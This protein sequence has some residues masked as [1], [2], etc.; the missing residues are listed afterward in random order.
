MAQEIVGIPKNLLVYKPEQ[1]TT[2]LCWQIN[3]ET[4]PTLDL[5][6]FEVEVDVVADFSSINKKTFT[7]ENVSNYQSGTFFKAFII[8]DPLLFET[9]TY[10]WRV[11]V[12]SDDYISEWSNY[13]QESTDDFLDKLDFNVPT[14]IKNPNE[15][16][17]I[18][19]VKT[20]KDG[21]EM[22]DTNPP[23][24][25][26]TDGIYDRYTKANFIT[27]LGTEYGIT[28]NVYEYV[29]PY[30]FNINKITWYDDTETAERLLPDNYVYTKSGNTNIKRIIEMYMRLIGVFKDEA[31]QV[32]NN[33]NYKKIQDADLYDLLGV[34][35]TYTRNTEEPFITYKYELLNLWQAYLHQ[36]TKAAFDIILETFFG[37]KPT[38]QL[39]KGKVDETWYVYNQMPLLRVDGAT[40]STLNIT[41]GDAFYNANIDK[42]LIATHGST[43]GDWSD[44]YEQEPNEMTTYQLVGGSNL[45]N[46]QYVGAS[47]GMFEGT[48]DVERYYVRHIE[49]ID[50]IFYP[51]AQPNPFLYTNQYLAHN[52]LITVNNVYGIEVDKE[53]LTEI[54]NMLKPLNINILLDIKDE[55]KECEINF[56]VLDASNN[57]DLTSTTPVIYQVYGAVISTSDNS[58]VVVEG[59]DITYKVFKNGYETYEGTI[60]NVSGDQNITIKLEPIYNGLKFTSNGGSTIKYTY[61]GST[62]P[63]IKYRTKGNAW[64]TWNSNVEVS[65]AD[66]EYM[67]IK[68][69]NPTGVS[70]SWENDNTTF[71]MTGAGTVSASG[72]VNSILDDGDGSTIT[73]LSSTSYAYAYLFSGCSKLVKA[74][75]LPTMTLGENCYWGMFND[76]TGLEETPSL[77]ATTLADNCYY[78]MFNG[79]SNLTK[80]TPLPA[81]TMAERCYGGM[82][83]DCVSLTDAPQLPAT[84]LDEYCYAEMFDG[85]ISL[86]TM[87]VLSCT[88][89]ANACYFRMFQDCTSLVNVTN[90]TATELKIGCYD[91]MFKGCT[92][93]ETAPNI[94]MTTPTGS[95]LQEMFYGCSSLNSITLV[96]YMGTFNSTNFSNWVY[97]VAASGDFYYNGEDDT[98]S[99]NAI[100]IGW[101]V[102]N[103]EF[104][105]LRFRAEEAG[106]TISYSLNTITPDI[107]YSY[108]GEEWTTWN[109]NTTITLT[110]VGDVVYVKGNNPN[111]IGRGDMDTN[112]GYMQFITGENSD[113]PKISA[114]GNI[115]SLLD[116]DDGSSITVLPGSL[117]DGY[118][119]CYY[120]LFR[121][122]S[123]LTKAPQ[124]PAIEVYTHS[125]REMFYGCSKL[126]AAPSLPAT[127]IASYCYYNMFYGCSSITTAPELPATK[128][129]YASYS[130][131]FHNCSNL[132]VAPELPATELGAY[133]YEAMFYRCTSLTTAPELLA[134]DMKSN[135]Y[136]SMY[137]M[138][139]SLTTVPKLPALSLAN[140]YYCYNSMFD[141]C[142]ALVN[143][144]DIYF[145]SVNLGSGITVCEEMFKNCISLKYI[146]L[147]NYTGTITQNRFRNWVSG[148]GTGGTIYYKGS[149]TTQGVSAI[150]Q[151]WTK[152]SNF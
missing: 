64:T 55:T 49:Q 37:V 5:L 102:H 110:N 130:H 145:E 43:T 1:H 66:G 95:A 73:S 28:D 47:N 112:N 35:L 76:C 86:E 75:E 116:D 8:E 93:L 51:T 81:M 88:T 52:V 147:V 10:Y 84:T 19:I 46:Y 59:A 127:E 119:W 61:N 30:E 139:T 87:P 123:N 148:V 133:C 103:T 78:F 151:G 18:V 98:E 65:L 149:T 24:S 63:D 29:G 97:G 25:S 31:M 4:E 21:V 115:N 104:K 135:C 134:M 118:A 105:G 3:L 79:C 9:Q 44:A 85:C 42:L 50:D 17:N 33:Y 122:C 99:V 62:T 16:D 113:S 150:P 120:R 13:K 11:R 96:K 137:G 40:P 82:F 58:L 125:Y 152:V 107:K 90:L 38:I 138:C 117:S 12:N 114:S 128:M 54:L 106:A 131:M 94:Y 14:E 74:P 2:A 136:E 70:H 7:K 126:S 92:S 100:P 142:S 26:Q 109:A 89:L 23:S 36:G 67:Y 68:G 101:T 77:P 129:Y 132:S 15:D 48:P 124:L 45:V 72:N 32:A 146:K 20:I 83:K 91:A 143:A 39:L 69:N 80:V 144:P 27:F 34:L 140:G 22:F 141:G 111:G 41:E 53:I 108:D 121:N 56:T 71:V 6:D 57:T 60:D